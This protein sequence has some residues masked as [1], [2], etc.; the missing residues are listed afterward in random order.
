[1]D[2]NIDRDSFVSVRQQIKGTIEY[3][4]SFG[5]Y[6]V[7]AQLPS[8]RELAEQTGVAPMTISAVYQDLKKEGLIETRNGSG[9]FVADSSQARMALGRD[10]EGLHRDIDALIDRAQSIGVRVAD[11]STLLNARIAHRFDIGRRAIVVMIGLFAEATA[12]YAQVIAAQLGDTAH[13]EGVTIS[14]IKADDALL[15]RMS[16]ADLVLCFATMHAEV[17]GLL[18]NSK[19]V[20]I[21]FIP[22]EQTRMALASLDPMSAVVAV[23]RFSTFVPILRSGVQRFAAHVQNITTYNIDDDAL[24]KALSNCNVVVFATGA[25][26]VLQSSPSGI[27]ALEYRHAPD[28]GDIRRLVMPFLANSRSSDRKEAS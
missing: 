4:I 6:V 27:Q 24:P 11:L 2:F 15:E 3:G 16:G 25:E 26:A 21:R 17:S 9:T 18:P 12:S 8:V 1:M 14:A 13:V 10:I 7:G 5:M 28:P 20:S 23:S 19:V 22:S